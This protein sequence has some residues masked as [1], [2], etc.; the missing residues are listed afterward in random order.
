MTRTRK[1][2]RLDT[3]LAT[4]RTLRSWYKHPADR[5]EL[6]DWQITIVELADEVERLRIIQ[7]EYVKLLSNPSE[8][9]EF[10]EQLLKIESLGD[11]HEK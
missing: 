7:T 5:R 4:A 1:S 10:I 3:H 11:T 6:T 8:L 2:L 9:R